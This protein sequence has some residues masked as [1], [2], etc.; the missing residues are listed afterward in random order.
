[1]DC[2]CESVNIWLCSTNITAIHRP[3]KQSTHVKMQFSSGKE[4]V[5]HIEMALDCN[6]S[7]KVTIPVSEL[8]ELSELTEAQLLTK[9][10]E[11]LSSGFDHNSDWSTKWIGENAKLADFLGISAPPKKRERHDDE[12]ENDGV[13][14]AAKLLKI[15]SIPSPTTTTIPTI[16]T[17]PTTIPTTTT[18]TTPTTTTT[19]TTQTTT[20]PSTTDMS[21]DAQV[22][23]VLLD[24]ISIFVEKNGRQPTDEEVKQWIMM[25]SEMSGDTTTTDI[26]LDT[27]QDTPFPAEPSLDNPTP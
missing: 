4:L 27:P 16:P 20:T 25:I 7:D 1:M 9:F 8:C 5:E 19:T 23:T 21:A 6:G 17:I 15:E 13:V 3:H 26:P 22:D 14:P 10:T 18:T 12:N 24:L 11:F 2:F